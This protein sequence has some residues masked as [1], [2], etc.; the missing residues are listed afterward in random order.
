MAKTAK[1]KDLSL[2]Q[3]MWNWVGGNEKNRG[4]VMDSV[5]FYLCLVV[6]ATKPH[7]MGIL[8]KGLSANST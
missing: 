5:L 4:T 8:L 1:V 2:E 3:I 7:Y 6:N